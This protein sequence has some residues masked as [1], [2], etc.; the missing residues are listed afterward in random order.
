MSEPQYDLAQQA[1]HPWLPWAVTPQLDPV[2]FYLLTWCLSSAPRRPCLHLLLPSY[3]RLCANKSSA[4]WYH[5]DPPMYSSSGCYIVW[6]RDRYTSV[7]NFL[8]SSSFAFLYAS[9]SFFASSRAS[10]TRFVR[11]GT[12]YQSVALPIEQRFAG[13]HEHSRATGMSAPCSRLSNFNC[14]G[15]VKNSPF[16]TIFWASLSAFPSLVNVLAI[17]NSTEKTHIEQ[18]LYSCWILCRLHWKCQCYVNN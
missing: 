3:C 6:I 5:C 10:F 7:S 12:A 16:C 17:A 14:I 18:S 11:S 8:N 9:T 4:Y 1:W 15:I 13:K 2:P